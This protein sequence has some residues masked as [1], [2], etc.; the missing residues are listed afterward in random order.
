MLSSPMLVSFALIL[1]LPLVLYLSPQ[2]L[3]TTYF[4]FSPDADDLS[5]FRRA[6]AA[7]SSSSS[8]AH[9]TSHLATTT[10]PKP[11]IAFLFLTNS[12][13]SFAPLWEKF[14]AGNHHLFNI[15]VHA[16]P[17][18]AVTSP[19][20][21][22]HRR[23]ISSKKTH[24]ASPTLIAAARR[25]LATALLDDP[26]NQ[27]FAVVSQH[28]I[29]L[30]SFRFAYNYLFKNPLI[31]LASFAGSEYNFSYRSFIEILS[32]EPNLFE[33]YSARGANTM[34]P[35]VPFD[36]FRVGS[37]FFIL[38]RRH[39]KLVVRDQRL[40]KKFKLPCI[41]EEPCYPEEHYFPTLLSMEDPN[42]CTGFT[43]TRVNWTGCWDG[44]PHLYN[45][46][47]V[48]PELIR[49]LRESNSTY[50]YL[51]ARK[52]SPECLAPLMEIANDVIFRE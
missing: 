8:A 6:T 3:P 10:N 47:E 1:S 27:Y 36:A 2:I 21:V 32:D 43:L 46:P 11:K 39:A 41:T 44:H 33:R 20:G 23:F 15:Y 35:E 4:P 31:S 38:T 25:L 18:A 29:P 9:T 51:F 16:D 5:L 42:G 37:Q 12:N 30:S 17:S 48:S 49:Q 28:C 34:L 22:F 13:L 19:G 45:P 40:W 50:S 7:P 14:F 26:L 52:F 24:R